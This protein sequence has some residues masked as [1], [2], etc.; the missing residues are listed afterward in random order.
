[1]TRTATAVIAGRYLAVWS[2]PDPAARRAAI[3]ELWAPDGAEFV[4]GVQ[5]RGHEELQGRVARA[6]Q[7]FVASGRYTVTAASDVTRHDDIVTMTVQLTDPGGEVAWAARVF[8]LLG[9][10][11]R[12]R[13]DYQLTVKPLA[14]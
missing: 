8:L 11:G 4:E 13:E 6:Y 7:E 10:D 12:V 14:A 1:M 5:F 3:E 9:Q 2:E